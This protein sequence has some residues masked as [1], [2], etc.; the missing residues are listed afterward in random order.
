MSDPLPAPDFART[1]FNV[2]PTDI[3]SG[4]AAGITQADQSVAQA[5]GSVSQVYT[6]NRNADDMLTAMQTNKMITPDEYEAVAGKSLGAKQQLLGMY[7]TEYAAQQA[8]ARA[9]AQQ[10][11]GGAVDIGV[12]HAKLLDTI[13]QLRQ[14]YST[15]PRKT[16]YQP[17]AQQPPAQQPPAQ[18]PP[19]GTIISKAMPGPI[20]PGTKVVQIKDEKGNLSTAYQTPDNKLIDP[21][22]GQVLQ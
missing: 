13:N 15:D 14:G 19:A 17:P 5:I 16:P 6:Q 18:Q 12:A 7:A 20:A 9:L 3:G 2:S 21:K 22:T 1:Q 10:R 8:Q 11:G 4:Y